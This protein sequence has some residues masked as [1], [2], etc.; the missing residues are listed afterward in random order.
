MLSERI[1]GGTQL[2]GSQEFNVV[3]EVEQTLLDALWSL[4]YG[5]RDPGEPAAP[6]PAPA[7]A[8]ASAP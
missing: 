4:T 2:A 6:K 7:P 8:P 3:F 1:G 5:P